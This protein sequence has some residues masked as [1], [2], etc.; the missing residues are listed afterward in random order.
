MNKKLSS[1]EMEL[2]ATAIGHAFGG[3]FSNNN[4]ECAIAFSSFKA[5]AAFTLA[6]EKK[7]TAYLITCIKRRLAS[8]DACGHP[9]DE[10]LSGSLNSYESGE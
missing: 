5:G 10:D 6:Y 3:E 1:Y 8:D 9:F 4:N 7:R 2:D